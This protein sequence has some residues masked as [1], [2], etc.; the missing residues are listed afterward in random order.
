VVRHYLDRTDDATPKD[1]WSYIS[2]IG[3]NIELKDVMDVPQR[4]ITFSKKLRQRVKEKKKPPLEATKEGIRWAL[5]AAG[6][7]GQYIKFVN[8]TIDKRQNQINKIKTLQGKFDKEVELLK[9]N[10]LEKIKD[11]QSSFAALDIQTVGDY[12]NQLLLEKRI[13]QSNLQNLQKDLFSMEKE[14]K[15]QE[16]QIGGVREHLKAKIIHGNAKELT[17]IDAIKIIQEEL[18]SIATK[19]DVSKLSMAVD[20]VISSK[21]EL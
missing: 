12:L 15:L 6:N 21:A 8:M 7:T 1:E 2:E 11:T 13:A 14:L 5:D 9:S 17:A 18:S 3:T 20:K 10:K 16:K 4:Y 19:Y